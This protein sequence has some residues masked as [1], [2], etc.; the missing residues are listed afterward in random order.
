MKTP[1]R[2]AGVVGLVATGL[3]AWL[4]ILGVG[5]P[6]LLALA[7]L[8]AVLFL[9]VPWIA[10][11]WMGDLSRLVRGRFW[12]PEQGHFHA[13]G[14]VPLLIEDDGCQ[15]WIDGQGLQRALGRRE[16]EDA[17]AAR[18]AGCWRRSAQGLLMLRVDA[19][20]HN[21]ATRPGR[22]DR[23]VQKLRRY[24]EREV[25]YPAQRRREAG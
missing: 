25:L 10:A 1:A 18:H 2:R 7:L 22:E 8:L 3:L 13:F 20:V 14:G 16:P 21:L 4:H 6:L 19:V 12:A 11:S 9:L 23:R 15:V 5:L 24:L 17:Q